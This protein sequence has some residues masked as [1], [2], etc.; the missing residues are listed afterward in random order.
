MEP[1]ECR[2]RS[3]T[4]RRRHSVTV[5]N[6]TQN[7]SMGNFLVHANARES[8]VRPFILVGLGATSLTTDLLRTGAA[9]KGRPALL[10]RLVLMR[11]TTW[12][13]I[14]GSGASLDML[15]PI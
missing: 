9:S 14:L 7:Q 1:Q 6:L 4:D 15:Q 10:L 8:R 2:H 3:P 13:N 11:N 12:V 5:F